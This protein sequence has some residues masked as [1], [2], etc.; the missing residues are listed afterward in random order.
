[1]RHTNAIQHRKTEVKFKPN[2]YH[3]AFEVLISKFK[4]K[5]FKKQKNAKHLRYQV[6]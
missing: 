2:Q 5:T 1:M 3:Q 6:N 4:L